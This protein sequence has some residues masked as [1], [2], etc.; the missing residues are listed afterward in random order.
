MKP[1]I[2]INLKVVQNRSSLLTRCTAAC[3]GLLTFLLIGSLNL[4]A[5]TTIHCWDFNAAANF[6]SPVST[7][8]R[9]AGTGTI[10]HNIPSTISSL[11]GNDA[12][13][14]SGSIAGNAFCPTVGAGNLANDS[15]IDFIFPTTGYE[16]ISFSFWFRRTATGFNDNILLY[17]TNGGTSFNELTTFSFTA[18]TGGTTLNFDFSAIPAVNDNPN[19]R[20]RIVLKDGSA[21]VGNNRYDNVKLEG[22]S[23]SPCNIPVSTQ[24]WQ[25]TDLNTPFL[26][27]FDNSV[28]GVNG[29]AFAGAGFTPTPGTGQLNSNAFI[30]GGWSDAPGS[31]G[32]GATSPATPPAND[33][34]RGTNSGNT[35]TGGVYGFDV[36]TGNRAFGIKP[37]TSDFN[38]GFITLRLQNQTGQP[39][40]SIELDYNVLVYNNGPRSNSFNFSYSLDNITFTPVSA[41]D[42][43]S[44][45]A[46]DVT[47][48]WQSNLK[49][50]VITNITLNDGEFLY[51]RWD[52]SDVSGT[53]A[54]DAFA[55]DDI[56]VVFL[57]SCDITGN[58]TFTSQAQLNAFA[59]TYAHCTNITVSG[60][61]FIFG[62]DI[63]DLTPLANLTTINGNLNIEF[64][65]ILQN[66]Q[67]LNGLTSI[68]GNFRLMGNYELQNLDGLN[69]L[70]SIGGFLDVFVNDELENLDGLS[71]L[72]SIGGF[73][74]ITVTYSLT[75]LDGLSQLTSIGGYLEVSDNY[76]LT[77][78]DGLSQVTS[79]G[80]NLNIQSNLSLTSLSGLE[81]VSSIGG[82]L[83]I[84]LSNLTSLSGLEGV[85]SIGGNLNISSNNLTSLS[86][87]ENLTSIGGALQ[88]ADNWSLTTLTGLENID[89]ATI[90]NLVIQN[91][92]NLSLCNLI[93]F[94]NYL[95]DP[96]NPRTI[97]GNDAGCGNELE[98]L[99]A[100][101]ATYPYNVTQNTYT[102]TIQEAVE[103]STCNVLNTV[104]IPTGNYAGQQVDSSGGCYEIFY[105]LGASPGCAT[106]A[107]WTL[108]G[109]DTVEIEIDGTTACTEYDQYEITNSLTLGG[110]TLD[111]VLGYAPAGG[112][113]FT[114]FDN[115]FG[116][117]VNGT[118][119]GL[120]E[121]EQFVVSGFDFEITYVGGDGN[122]IVL[123]V[124]FTD[125]CEFAT[126]PNPPTLT[127][128]LNSNC[129]ADATNPGSVSP[130]YGV[131]GGPGCNSLIWYNSNNP[132]DIK[133]GVAA[134]SGLF[135]GADIGNGQQFWIAVTNNFNN[136]PAVRS[137][138]RPIT[139]DVVDIIP[140]TLNIQNDPLPIQC[141]SL[142][143][144]TPTAAQLAALVLP[145]PI[146]DPVSITQL[147]RTSTYTNVDINGSGDNYLVVAPGAAVNVEFNRS[148]SYTGGATGCPGC[149]TQ[150]YIGLAGQT[151]SCVH[152]A[153]GGS[154]GFHS[155]NFTA[156]MTPGVY[157]ITQSGS[158]WFFC[159]QFGN[160]IANNNP[161]NAIGVVVVTN[162]PVFTLGEDDNCGV[163]D[164]TY[165]M[166]NETEVCNGT[167]V[168]REYTISVVV[169]DQSGNSSAAEEFV[170]EVV[171]S[172]S[173]PAATITNNNTTINCEDTLPDP[174]WN[175]AFAGGA[176]VFADTDDISIVLNS[177][178]STQ[179]ADPLVCGHYNY[180]VTRNYTLTN[181]CN[182]N[183][184]NIDFVIN[185]EDDEDPLL[186]GAFL[187]NAVTFTQP[188]AGNA[189][190]GG[191]LT[192]TAQA[193]NLNDVDP[194]F[195][196]L[197]ID[198]AA[199]SFV[200]D[201]CSSFNNLE[202]ELEVVEN[203][204]TVV[205]PVVFKAAG[206]A[207][208]T[209]LDRC[210][211]IGTST[212]D[213]YYYR[214]LWQFRSVYHYC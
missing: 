7:D 31:I 14:C 126:I 130:V 205:G 29:R 90:T 187:G 206:A 63:T 69:G 189:L 16:D 119:A 145:A 39:V 134:T 208:P 1:T 112:D 110:A 124:L 152:D 66:L 158:W 32:F 116:G 191:T 76:V 95:S 171:D 106:F 50:T 148:T 58:L 154:A 128:E 48:S 44:P 207:A 77:N 212:V 78:L 203:G 13:A 132:A 46:A 28:P 108:D 142:L 45:L 74:R 62:T 102:S 59:A 83:N 43:V 56:E 10:E 55:L 196:C 113:T 82:N 163:V 195:G 2:T 23:C 202:I 186:D 42:F 19:F 183:T 60:N 157:Y 27:D 144:A 114:I 5:Q 184:Q 204:T 34:A 155:L 156:S 4:T 91:N 26:I 125:Q 11:G 12:N 94:C 175:I 36:G 140:P 177:T 137:Q 129:E 53:G 24:G 73:L 3:F 209:V 96:A 121:G 165:T 71:Q 182:G 80:G 111:V 138:L 194:C 150:H 123:T 160:L 185:V 133:G 75:N 72:T 79:I 135:T 172:V 52:G 136:D 18:A 139:I 210:Y 180:T 49:N 89:P 193:N 188:H 146:S 167:G 84:S 97:S 192:I 169:T 87:L 127:F 199:M 178:M 197:S 143:S 98:V 17:S 85:T 147:G 99:V 115:T 65:H 200:T 68:G 170:V 181:D 168:V 190:D 35:T 107:D 149:V 92:S 88:I 104:N 33:F 20:I 174:V 61:V 40:G 93:N 70:S 6:S 22:F 47:P 9:V 161:A 81:G 100:C 103:A 162:D 166:V 57:P 173:T 64:N 37:G 67:G 117:P 41:L 151:S 118:F 201:N 86:G 8:H 120:P 21:T 25:I 176:C 101:G 51:L 122:D 131:T 105:Q 30:T 38:P 109:T 214:P 213:I 54:R 164:Y 141:A 211:P 198:L 159:N 179:D 153:V 15:H